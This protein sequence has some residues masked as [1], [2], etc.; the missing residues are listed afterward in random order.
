MWSAWFSLLQF[1]AL[2]LHKRPDFYIEHEGCGCV[3]GSAGNAKAEYSNLQES[4]LAGSG[5]GLAVGDTL[6]WPEAWAVIGMPPRHHNAPC[7]WLHWKRSSHHQDLI[8]ADD[9]TMHGV[10]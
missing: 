6:F 1:E 9:A 2:Q 7:Q 3:S 8:R 5:E 10:R 4:S